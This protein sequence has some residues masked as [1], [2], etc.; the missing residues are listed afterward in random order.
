M[1]NAAVLRIAAGAGAFLIALASCTEL[2]STKAPDV[3]APTLDAA[4]VL[5]S[6][7]PAPGSTV[8]VM[9]QI[10]PS[11]RALVGSYTA[12]IRYDSTAL[13]FQEELSIADGTTRATNATSGLVRFAGAAPAGIATGRLAGFRF[14]VLRADAVRSLQLV[15][16]ELHTVSRADAAS[17]VRLAPSRTAVAP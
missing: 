14:L 11:T 3:T 12:R 6:T 13:R 1:T 8:D 16:D 5:S 7:A 10:G 17:L 4:L 2:A 9:A 15:V